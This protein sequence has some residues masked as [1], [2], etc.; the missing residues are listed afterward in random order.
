MLAAIPVLAIRRH[1]MGRV[2]EVR[3]DPDL[4]CLGRRPNRLQSLGDLGPN[5]AGEILREHGDR[6]GSTVTG[7][8]EPSCSGDRPCTGEQSEL[9]GDIGEHVLNVEHQWNPSESTDHRTCWT[10]RERWRHRQHAIRSDRAAHADGGGQRG[11]PTECDCTGRDVPLVGGKGID[12]GDPPPSGVLGTHQ[13][14]LPSGLDRMALVP[15]QCGDDMESV[16]A[17]DEFVG[18][19]RHDGAGGRHVGFEMR[20][21][22]DEIHWAELFGSRMG[23]PRYSSASESAESDQR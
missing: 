16:P 19:P 6:V 10:E 14:T 3:N 2:D 21:Q 9:D 20:T 18:D 11:E 22:D 12:P 17:T 4:R 13:P 15:R 7:P 5:V 1:D 8:L 23:R